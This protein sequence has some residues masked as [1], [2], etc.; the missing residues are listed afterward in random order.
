MP[1]QKLEPSVYALEGVWRQDA[2]P[3]TL[4][5]ASTTICSEGSSRRRSS[6]SEENKVGPSDG[7]VE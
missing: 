7:H 5:S 2:L 3:C 6:M 1:F 4:R